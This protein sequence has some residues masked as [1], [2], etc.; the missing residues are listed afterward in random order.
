M[1]L[2]FKAMQLANIFAGALLVYEAIAALA[3]WIHS[4]DHED[5]PIKRYLLS[6]GA[7]SLGLIPLLSFWRRLLDGRLEW[8]EI[9]DDLADIWPAN[10]AMVLLFL[11]IFLFHHILRQNKQDWLVQHRLM[12][13]VLVV[14]FPV[15]YLGMF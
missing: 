9:A 11:L 3:L 4:K 5:I 1:E 12:I 6:I 13:I 10:A 14:S 15:T 2:F 8:L 7:V